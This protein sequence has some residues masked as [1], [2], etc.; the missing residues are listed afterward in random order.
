MHNSTKSATK[1][2]KELVNKLYFPPDEVMV[3][4]ADK[5]LRQID[6]IKATRLGNADRYKVKITFED[7]ESVKMVHTTIWAMTENRIV[8]KKGVVIPV[9]RIHKVDF[10]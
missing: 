1:I 4:P 10:L 2:K 5:T 3:D 6:I 7:D 9:H 8:L